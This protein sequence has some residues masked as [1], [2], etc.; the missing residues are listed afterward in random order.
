MRRLGEG[1]IMGE[2]RECDRCHSSWIAEAGSIGCPTCDP[3]ERC[4]DCVECEALRPL[5]LFGVCKWKREVPGEI[6]IVNRGPEPEKCEG[7]RRKEEE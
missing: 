7:F 2:R 1:I 3:E 5:S 6:A 4:E